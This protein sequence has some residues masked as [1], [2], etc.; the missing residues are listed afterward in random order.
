VNSIGVT[1]YGPLTSEQYRMVFSKALELLSAYNTPNWVSD[2]SHQGQITKDD[3]LWMLN[4]I[5][6][7]AA[8]NGL[9]RIA[10]VQSA[11][12]DTLVKEYLDAI[13]LNISKF[14]IRYRSFQTQQETIQWIQEENEKMISLNNHD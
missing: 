14:G 6:P 13:E 7:E 5:L 9:K 10:S 4:T 2:I 8:K 11:N 12:N 1:W 3:Q